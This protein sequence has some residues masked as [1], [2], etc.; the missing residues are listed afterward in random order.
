VKVG[1][2]TTAATGH[3]DLLTDPVRPFEHDDT[4]PA[5][6]GDKRAHESGGTA[7]KNDYIRIR[8]AATL[9]PGAGRR[10]R[11]LRNGFYECG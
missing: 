11:I 2:I 3:E 4:T 8:H 10:R 1:E 7:A 5:P 6:A 9:A